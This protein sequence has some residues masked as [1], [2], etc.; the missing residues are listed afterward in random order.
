MIRRSKSCAE[1]LPDA[2]VASLSHL[3]RPGFQTSKLQ[4]W[5]QGTLFSFRS[6][7]DLKR[8]AMHTFGPLFGHS[9]SRLA[10]RGPLWRANAGMLKCKQLFPAR[11]KRIEVLQLFHIFLGQVSFKQEHIAGLLPQ[12]VYPCLQALLSSP[13]AEAPESNLCN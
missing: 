2:N 13:G 12:L 4:L 7:E 9:S 8:N 3:V 10:G 11:L 6:E 5:L 1:T